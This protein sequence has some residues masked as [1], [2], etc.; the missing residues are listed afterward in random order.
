[1][2]DKPKLNLKGW[3]MVHAELH[4]VEGPLYKI[5]FLSEANIFESK[6]TEIFHEKEILNLSEI[7][8]DNELNI[9]NY[10]EE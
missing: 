3:G 4:W 6:K 5:S 9:S 8:I 1:M 2:S 7:F 10:D